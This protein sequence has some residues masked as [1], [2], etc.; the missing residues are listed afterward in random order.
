M[1]KTT[2]VERDFRDGK[3]LIERLD[4]AKFG[5]HS[6]FWIFNSESGLWRLIIATPLVE[7]QSQKE[8]YK[9]IKATIYAIEQPFNISLQNIS[10]ISPSHMIVGTLRQFFGTLSDNN[11]I[12]GIRF[13]G[14]TINN[15]F[16]EDAYIYRIGL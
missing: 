9:K 1:D 16:I 7:I 10:V 12:E 13:S 6:A 8:A 2:L 14:S 15:S 11:R 5:V 3:K 4:E